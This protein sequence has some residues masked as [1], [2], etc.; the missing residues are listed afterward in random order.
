MEPAKAGCEYVNATTTLF[1]AACLTNQEKRR[2][3]H[4][5]AEAPFFDDLRRHAASH[6]GSAI[7]VLRER[8]CSRMVPWLTC[9]GFG[10]GSAPCFNRCRRHARRQRSDFCGREPVDQSNKSHHCRFCGRRPLW[11]QAKP[12]KGVAL[13]EEAGPPPTRQI[14]IYLFSVENPLKT[15]YNGA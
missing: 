3:V 9:R 4:V 1:F 11:P 14:S 12:V 5:A 7:I 6:W 15:C 2:S 10:G 13:A 8:R